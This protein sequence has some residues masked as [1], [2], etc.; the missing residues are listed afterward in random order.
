M[1]KD[2]KC[3]SVFRKAGVIVVGAALSASISIAPAFA[4]SSTESDKIPTGPVTTTSSYITAAASRA[5]GPA[6]EILGLSSVEESGNF[7]NLL[8]LY[9]WDQPKYYL[10]ASYYNSVISPFLANFAIGE[11]DNAAVYNPSRSGGGA[12]PNAALSTT[13]QSDADVLAL[14]PDVI[15]GNGN[16]VDSSA[17]AYS[18]SDYSGLAD[19]MDAIAEAADEA[20]AADNVVDEE[21]GEITDYGRELRYEQSAAEIAT[22]YRQ[23]IFGSMGAVQKA[24]NDGT[25]TKKKVAVVQN[26]YYDSELESYV[27]DLMKTTEAGK[28]GTASK[29]RYLETTSN[30]GIAG[31]SL[32]DN[33]ADTKEKVTYDELKANVD[34]ILVGG[35]SSSSNYDTIIDGLLNGKAGDA[36]LLGKTYYVIDNGSQGAMY[37]VVM[38]SVENAQNVGRIL[39]M[40]YPTVV[41]QQNWMAYYYQT[42][43]HISPASLS[44]AMNNALAGVRC[45]AATDVSSQEAAATWNVSATGYESGASQ[46]TVAESISTGYAYFQQVTGRK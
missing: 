42:F 9:N 21:T 28:D 6:P 27:F 11:T 8:D 43:Y 4:D 19:T 2:Y 3:K 10:A 5:A 40:L 35:Q 37:G 17:V 33:Y 20:A 12:G 45:Q 15:I 13:D 31:I 23:Y 41:N 46:E 14:N 34:L 32:A 16:G 22:S 30:T 1:E 25:V 36:G 7:V 29:N 39:G 26:Y 18:F 38:N 24:I 44:I